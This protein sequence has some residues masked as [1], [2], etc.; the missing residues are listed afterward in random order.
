[1]ANLVAAAKN[2][3]EIKFQKST[4]NIQNS[5]YFVGYTLK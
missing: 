1:M 2:L 5:A 3:S 4:R